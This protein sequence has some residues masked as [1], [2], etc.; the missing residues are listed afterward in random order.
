MLKTKISMAKNKD[1]TKVLNKLWGL[2]S[3]S[4]EGFTPMRVPI[5][6]WS[7]SAAIFPLPTAKTQ[8]N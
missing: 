5:F 8:L 7:Q 2:Q 1:F 3:P 4:P 6:T